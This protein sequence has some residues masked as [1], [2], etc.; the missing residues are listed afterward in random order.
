MDFMT[1]FKN[2]IIYKKMKDHDA[3]KVGKIKV[4]VWMC[5]YKLNTNHPYFVHY[6]RVGIDSISRDE[7]GAP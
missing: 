2:K 6:H 7:L 5:K 4:V 1:I 3:K